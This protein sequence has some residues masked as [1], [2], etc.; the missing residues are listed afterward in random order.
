[1]FRGLFCDLSGCTAGRSSRSCFGSS[2]ARLTCGRCRAERSRSGT[3][4]RSGR[5][6][7]GR[8]TQAWLAWCWA[9]RHGDRPARGVIEQVR[10]DPYLAADDR[11]ARGT[12]ADVPR[13]GAWRRATVMVPVLNVSTSGRSVVASFTSGRRSSVS[14]GLPFNVASYAI[15]NPC[16][17]GTA[18]ARR[19]RP[20]V[21]TPPVLNH[22]D[23]ARELF[24]ARGAAA[25]RARL[26]PAVTD[27]EAFT[28]RTCGA[29]LQP[30][31][32]DQGACGR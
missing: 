25:A 24:V 29:R 2:P 6:N 18:C 14:S 15:L 13:I 31:P 5:R 32:A 23:Q 17:A 20:H 19:L 22:L 16:R 28:P 11:L 12:S 27:I 4:W 21:P 7:L 10:L 26:N 1:V 8:G 3:S 30:A 9:E